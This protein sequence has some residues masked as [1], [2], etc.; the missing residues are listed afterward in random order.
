MKL[1][2]HRTAAVV[3][4]LSLT[5]VSGCKE[6]S[7]AQ[8]SSTRPN[9]LWV[10]WDTVRADHLS[11]YGYERPT[12]PRLE[13]WAKGARVFENCISTATSTV[14]SHA[15]MFTGLLPSEHGIHNKHRFLD[16]GYTTVAERFGEAGYQTYLFAANP[17]ISQDEN[18]HQGFDVEEHPWSP[19]YRDE[20]IRILQE[21]LLPD[22]QGGLARKIRE[23]AGT[24]WNIKAC[25]ALAQK[26]AEAWLAQRD[27]DRPFF[28]F[29]NYMEA[30]EPY[31]PAESYRRLM[32]SPEDVRRSCKLG[33]VWPA[34]WYHSFGLKS[35][36]DEDIAIMGA[37]Y[38][39]TLRELD[40]LFAELI[41]SL[42]AA[43][44]LDNTIVVLT[45]DHGE[46]LGDHHMLDHQFALYNPLIHVPLVLHYPQGVE[47][48]RDSRPVM[49][50]DLFPTLLELAG[51]DLPPDLNT[52]AR[53]LLAPLE[54]RLRIAEYPAVFEKGLRRVK[55]GYPDWDP[56][57]WRRTFR[58]LFADDHKYIWASDDRHE[59]YDLADDPGELHNLVTTRADRAAELDALL[60]EQVAAF[61]EPLRS[62][63][64]RPP[65]RDHQ[66][67]LE[68]LGYAGT[69]EDPDENPSAERDS[70]AEE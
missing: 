67:R 41:A 21:K 3:A 52:R 47:P 50:F 42:E 8:S 63:R 26:G 33:P 40:D 15:S 68:N 57:P 14:P 35:Y 30:H 5:I 56:S 66:T 49:N 11:L 12:T 62:I 65:S 25:G 20:A 24:N 53:S 36:S 43:G 54:A 29:L 45:A 48:G 58:A 4:I 13:E 69:D 31:I 1:S 16:D 6:S 27:P 55:Q 60:A 17:H 51:L 39:A 44:D 23:G 19:Q 70:A 37:T 32:M 22:D 28:I 2:V 10:V 9:V 61:A 34:I 7:R 64:A 18:F 59:L 38:D 46:H